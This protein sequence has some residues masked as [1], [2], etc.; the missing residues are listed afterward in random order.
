MPWVTFDINKFKGRV[1]RKDEYPEYFH[2]DADDAEVE[3][4]KSEE[5]NYD[6]RRKTESIS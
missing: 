6:K 2:L 3:E 4:K 1:V 5:R